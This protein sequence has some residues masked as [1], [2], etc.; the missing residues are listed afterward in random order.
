MKL[1][2]D[3][4]GLAGFKIRRSEAS[5]G[6]PIE[7]L[8]RGMVPSGRISPKR[9]FL[10]SEFLPRGFPSAMFGGDGGDEG[11]AVRRVLTRARRGGRRSGTGERMDGRKRF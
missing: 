4:S 1:L 9:M 11:I 5:D 6:V 10:F 8:R 3:G 7:F 2:G